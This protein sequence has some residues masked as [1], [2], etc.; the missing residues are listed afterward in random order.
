MAKYLPSTQALQCFDAVAELLSVTRASQ[1]L[2]MTQSAVSRQ[3]AGLEAGL[4][5]QLFRR[6]KQR[7]YLT[8]R[9][10]AYWEEVRELLRRLHNASQRLQGKVSGRVRLGVEPAIAS[11]WLVPR[12]AA[13]KQRH[14][15]LDIELQTDLE[16]LYYESDSYDIA[17]LYGLGEWPDLDAEFLM[18]DTLVAVSSPSLLQQFGK[19]Q[20][21]EDS[22]RF[23]LLHHT[24]KPS[25]S[26]AWLKSAGLS[27]HDIDALPGSRLQSFSLISQVASEGLGL[28]ILPDYFVAADI[29]EGKLVL[30]CDES[31]PCEERYFVVRPKGRGEDL[32]VDAVKQWLLG[33]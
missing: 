27:D 8:E 30:A 11:R 7:L 13:F 9:G 32:A 12:L 1:R 23:P 22:L 29:Q 24:S 26:G 17:I 33:L 20:R 18:A 28:A 21:L 6:E 31:L 15:E 10:R 16:A 2:N 14:P 4:S 5:V 3:I 19:I 25:S